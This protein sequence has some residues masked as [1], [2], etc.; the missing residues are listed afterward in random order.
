MDR[1]GDDR[2]TPDGT[3]GSS[4]PDEP[5]RSEEPRCCEPDCADVAA[6]RLRIPWND[7][8]VV[9]PA[10]A[11]GLSQRDGVVAEPLDGSDDAWP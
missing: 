8:R 2:T 4:S 11:R 9:C 6:V 7:D 1:P 3:D 10:C 5:H